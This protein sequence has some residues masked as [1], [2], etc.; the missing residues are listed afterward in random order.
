M[1]IIENIE[2]NY[3]NLA[4]ESLENAFYNIDHEND[5]LI[6]KVPG[7][8]VSTTTFPISTPLL[9]A[10]FINE[11]TSLQF[12]GIRFE[13]LTQQGNANLWTLESHIGGLKI[14]R[15]KL[16]NGILK[17]TSTQIGNTLRPDIFNL[18]SGGNDIFDSQAIAVDYYTTNLNLQANSGS[19]SVKINDASNMKVGSRVILGPSTNGAGGSEG[20]VEERAVKTFNSL[21]GVVTFNVPL[22]FTYNGG[23]EVT[24]HNRIYLFNNNSPGFTSP[25]G[26]GFGGIYIIS[27][28]NGSIIK[29]I[30]GVL[31]KDVQGAVFDPATNRVVISKG[32]QLLFMNPEDLTFSKSLVMDNF[33]SVKN[34]FFD[35]YDLTISS[36][37][38]Y[39]LQ[40]EQKDEAGATQGFDD[41]GVV[42]TSLLPLVSS[43][44]VRPEKTFLFAAENDQSIIDVVVRT[45]EGI[46]V[47]DIPINV[48]AVGSGDDEEGV[49]DDFDGHTPTQGQTDPTGRVRFLYLSGVNSGIV[50]IKAQD[51][52]ELEGLEAESKILQFDD[53][54][55]LGNLKQ[56]VLPVSPIFVDQGNSDIEAKVQIRTE[57]FVSFPPVR[58]TL[59]LGT[60]DNDFLDFHSRTRDIYWPFW[61]DVLENVHNFSPPP[62]FETSTANP[63]MVKQFDLDLEGIG[64]IHQKI[65]TQQ[66]SLIDQRI[67]ETVVE[68]GGLF[69]VGDIQGEE[70][71][72]QINLIDL[73]LPPPF[74]IKNP[75]DTNLFFRINFPG[76]P[77]NLF[78]IKLFVQLVDVTS[79][80]VITTEGLTNQ[81]QVTYNPP[82]DFDFG[83]R[84][85]VSL[86]FFDTAGT[87]NFY[88]LSHYFDIIPDVRA[89]FLLNLN[90]VEGEVGVPV[91]T[92]IQFDLVDFDNDVDESSIQLLVNSCEI[93]DYETIR[94]NNGY[95][96]CYRPESPF[97]FTMDVSVYIEALDVEGNKVTKSYKFI[98]EPSSLPL[99][100]RVEPPNCY[101]LIHRDEPSIFEIFSSGDGVDIH[102]IQLVINGEVKRIFIKPLIRR[103][104]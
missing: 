60:P 96:V 98:T 65:V 81:V 91:D 22:Q 15:F 89:P 25:P 23:N 104:N 14:R 73:I 20:K 34:G 102:T 13:N 53:L 2:F 50:T 10:D 83:E 100:T 57:K 39:R 48:S 46:G 101:Q 62:L 86:E 59:K 76:F 28:V 11:T 80:I 72:T 68:Q 58:G 29:S 33:S 71:L 3:P 8:S 37:F 92:K 79:D 63:G 97:S 49:F 4:F 9:E 88:D 24:Y 61:T 54:T 12:T 41:F 87:P 51:G 6:K 40:A 5:L 84:V 47:E 38:I 64:F 103:I 67:G 26:I 69:Q 7:P 21:T 90:P 74:S 36:S 95:T 19:T 66:F 85:F 42:T 99:V 94:I 77:I 93:L 44:S 78:S 52:S 30:N 31:F 17:F 16:E 27:P 43:I 35:I 75:L 56:E 32:N 1:S 18:F 82:V 45:Q 70:E 55:E